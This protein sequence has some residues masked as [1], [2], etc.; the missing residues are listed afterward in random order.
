MKPYKIHLLMTFLLFISCSGSDDPAGSSS[1]LPELVLRQRM[2]GAISTVGKVDWYY[3]RAAEANTIMQVRCSSETI[4][5]DVDLLVTVFQQDEQGNR[6]RLYAD[7]APDNGIAPADLKL[8]V[9]IDQPKD[10][11]ISVRDLMDDD[12]SDHPYYLVVDFSSLA[13]GNDSFAQARELAVNSDACLTDSIESIGDIDCFSFASQGGIY[14][15]SVAFSPLSGSS[16]QLSVDLYNAL[17]Q[18]IDRQTGAN[19]RNFELTHFLPAGVYYVQ[20]NDSGRDDF[21]QGSV[22]SVCLNALA[23]VEANQN[24]RQE[25]A[26]SITL[27]AFGSEN[28]IT[29]SLDYITDA[30]WYRISLP[31]PSS[32]FRVLDL[33]FTGT[34]AKEYLVNVLDQDG[35]A[36]LSHSFNG[37]SPE[38][39]TLV[40]L[41]ESACYFM[42]TPATGQLEFQ[43]MPYTAMV[44]ALNITDDAEVAPNGNDTIETADPLMPTSDPSAATSGKIGFRGD[45]DWYSVTIPAHADPQILEVFLEAPLSLVEYS[46]SIMNN[47][48]IE[49]L[50]NNRSETMATSLKTGL[51]IPA[52]A[53]DAVYSFKVHDFQDDDGDDVT[54]TIRTDIRDIPAVLPA[55]AAGSPPSGEAIQYYNEALESDTDSISLY[56]NP[57]STRTFNVDNALL[58]NAGAVQQ[59][60]TPQAGLTTLTFPWLAGY[61]DYKGDQDWF[62]IDLS[63]LDASE[64]WYCEIQVELYAPATD[65]EYVWKFFPDVPNDGTLSNSR[66]SYSGF[67]ASAGDTTI[68]ESPVNIVTPSGDDDA[69]WIGDAWSGEA[70]FSISDF[71]FVT[72]PSGG[73]NP[74]PDDDWGGYGSAPYYFQVTLVYHPGESR[75]E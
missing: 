30:D 42:V 13:Q 45:A 15:L 59:A 22:Y 69:F 72:L 39:R 24:D 2:A 4:R 14:D 31:D 53:Q 6:T 75:P 32:G 47:S 27:A 70:Y 63:P 41:D 1:G 17:G 50:F 44:K 12:A 57:D 38:Y 73:N 71:N 61:V 65:V 62:K 35:E 18:R 40:K 7:H 55:A 74:L 51:L 66:G 23:N 48:L 28:N 3:F 68:T 5:P 8:N 37:G 46:L 49:R 52:N 21:D 67:I 29:G 19:L 58:A 34:A 33:R 54:Y 26:E 10:I 9:Y 36:I 60:D 56:I 43:A 25:D 11:V 64:D 20:V 16:V